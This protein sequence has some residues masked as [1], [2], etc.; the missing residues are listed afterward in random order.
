MFIVRGTTSGEWGMKSHFWSQ[1]NDRAEGRNFRV[2][3]A[4]LVELGSIQAHSEP[5]KLD[6]PVQ[7]VVHR[8]TCR[9]WLLSRNPEHPERRRF[10]CAVCWVLA[11]VLGDLP[12]IE[13]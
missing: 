4:F 2:L 8:T 1:V 11:A 6:Q 12:R 10:G 9:D 7:R 13:R 5:A 3:V